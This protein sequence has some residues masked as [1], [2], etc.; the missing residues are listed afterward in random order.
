MQGRLAGMNMAGR[1][2][3]CN[4]SL[5]RNVI[6][7]FDL[8]VMT[9]GWNHPP[10]DPRFEILTRFH[11]RSNTYRRLVFEG[12]RLIGA[13]LV[14]HIESGGILMTMIQNAI[15][16]SIPRRNLLQ[17]PISPKSVMF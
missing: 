2:V 15:P 3:A 12:N 7:I 16:I 9:A 10:D 6:R 8:D 13:T 17:F 4:G 11:P 14:N 1:S 5:S